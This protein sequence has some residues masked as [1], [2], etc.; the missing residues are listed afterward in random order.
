MLEFAVFDRLV[1]DVV[2][3]VV[4]VEVPGFAT[5]V[6]SGGRLVN[7]P[8]IPA[9]GLGVDDALELGVVVECHSYL[10]YYSSTVL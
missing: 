2:E 10:I 5:K 3:A 9:V 7:A 1:I 6:G 4:V 8:D